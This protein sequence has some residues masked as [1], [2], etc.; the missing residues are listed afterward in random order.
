MKLLFYISYNLIAASVAVS[1]FVSGG[2][3]LLIPT[4]MVWIVGLNT[5]YTMNWKL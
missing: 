5:I 3:T 4:M 1:G 2:M